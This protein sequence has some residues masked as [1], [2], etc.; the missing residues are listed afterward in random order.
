M[1]TKKEL[2]E[3]N[4]MNEET[5]EQLKWDLFDIIYNPSLFKGTLRE[6]LRSIFCD[7]L[8]KRKDNLVKLAEYRDSTQN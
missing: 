6:E 8:R 1:P 4:Q 7:F 3:R 5:I 2:Q